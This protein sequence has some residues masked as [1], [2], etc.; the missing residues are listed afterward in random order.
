[1]IIDHIGYVVKDL[2]K[3]CD[4]NCSMMNYKIK[5]PE[6]YVENQSVKIIMLESISGITP[7]LELI[8]PVGDNSPVSTALKKRNIINHICYRTKNYDE[9]VQK[10]HKKIVRPSMPA[11]VE[12]F[13]GGRTFFAYLNGQ[14]T[15]FVE[16]IGKK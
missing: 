13:G 14:V 2:A 11:P 1:M 6:I 16:D 4:F 3:S 5:V 9:I 10:F 12:L 7:N 8:H 15:E